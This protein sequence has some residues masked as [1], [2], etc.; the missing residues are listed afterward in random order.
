MSLGG[1]E[2]PVNLLNSCLLSD[3]FVL[4]EWMKQWAEWI[5]PAFMA[6][7]A[8]GECHSQGVLPT[9]ANYPCFKGMVLVK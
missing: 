9:N 8:R 7:W 6:L 5:G 1:A 3:D 4:A 2:S